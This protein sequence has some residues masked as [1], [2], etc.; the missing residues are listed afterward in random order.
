M[1]TGGKEAAFTREDTDEDSDEDCEDE[2]EEDDIEMEGDIK[3]GLFTRY[4]FIIKPATSHVFGGRWNYLNL[5]TF[6][7][8]KLSHFS[9]SNP[10]F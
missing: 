7:A 2:G 3:E 1:D 6:S 10:H 8:P 4:Q 5:W 9:N